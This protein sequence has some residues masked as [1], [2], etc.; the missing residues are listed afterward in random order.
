LENFVSGAAAKVV[1]RGV[2]LVGTPANALWSGMAGRYI[3]CGS[4]GGLVTYSGMLSGMAYQRIGTS[5]SGGL[6]INI[7][8]ELT[9]GAVSTPLPGTLI[10]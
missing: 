2:A 6:Y 4:G 7:S 10:G 1:V 9:S 8:Q 5:F 3:F